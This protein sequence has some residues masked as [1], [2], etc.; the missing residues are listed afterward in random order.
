MFFVFKNNLLLFFSRFLVIKT[1]EQLFFYNLVGLVRYSKSVAEM[2]KSC[3][4]P[5]LTGRNTF[6]LMEDRV[7]L[8]QSDSR[9]PYAYLST[10]RNVVKCSFINESCN[11]TEMQTWAVNPDNVCAALTNKNEENHVILM[12]HSTPNSILSAKTES[13]RLVNRPF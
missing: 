7:P 2:K 8:S 13:K 9:L 10:A 6:S 5:S 11:C 12:S 1:D 4:L 3:A